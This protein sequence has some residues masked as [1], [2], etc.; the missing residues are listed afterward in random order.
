MLGCR[1]RRETMTDAKDDLKGARGRIDALD[2]E[3]SRLLQE[4]AGQ[5]LAAARAKRALGMSLL[6]EAR[7]EDVLAGLGRDKGPLDAAGMRRIYRV[8][9]EEMRR[10]EEKS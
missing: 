7:E 6:D 1:F 3:I 2:R 9:M 8:I 4:R 10:A 5:A